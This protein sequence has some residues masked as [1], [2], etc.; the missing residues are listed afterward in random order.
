MTEVMLRLLQ[1]AGL[2]SSCILHFLF[3]DFASVGPRKTLP[4]A[5][6]KQVSGA[7]ASVASA[8]FPC[9]TFW[10]NL[11]ISTLGPTDRGMMRSSLNV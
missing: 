1:G 2:T 5:S 8:T 9:T 11:L 4:Q 6:H 10:R 7:C 3:S